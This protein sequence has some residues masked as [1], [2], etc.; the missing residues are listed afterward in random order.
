MISNKNDLKQEWAK[1][2]GAY[3]EKLVKSMPN[4][5]KAVQKSKVYPTKY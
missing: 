5:L 2:T 4:H 1:I 3:C